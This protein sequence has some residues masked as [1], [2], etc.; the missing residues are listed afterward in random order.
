MGNS[1]C[2]RPRVTAVHMAMKGAM[3][4]PKA[5]VACPKVIVEVTRSP[6]T[7]SVTSGFMAT[8]RMVLPMPIREKATSTLAKLYAR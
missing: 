5:L 1:S 2:Q 7:T 6:V 3:M 4:L 8:C